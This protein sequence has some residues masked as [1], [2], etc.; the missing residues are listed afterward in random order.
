M[1]GGGDVLNLSGGG[2]GTMMGDA[3]AIAFLGVSDLDAAGNL[4]SISSS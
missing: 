4:L 3:T 1:S 2:G